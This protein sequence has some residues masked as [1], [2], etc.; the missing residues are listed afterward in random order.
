MFKEGG[1]DAIKNTVSDTSAQ[2][3]SGMNYMQLICIIWIMHNS[4]YA[5]N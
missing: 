3:K 2:K 4:D 5:S 1:L